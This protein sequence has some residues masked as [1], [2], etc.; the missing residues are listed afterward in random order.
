[1]AK[2]KRIMH[3]Y[4]PRPYQKMKGFDTPIVD[5][6]VTAVVGFI[7]YGPLLEPVL[8]V[9]FRATLGKAVTLASVPVVLWLILRGFRLIC[10]TSVELREDA[11]I[12]SFGRAGDHMT[13]LVDIESCRLEIQE[14][15]GDSFA[16][17]TMN[18]R[19]QR[20]GVAKVPRVYQTALPLSSDYRRLLE[21][22]R[23]SDVNVLSTVG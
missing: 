21:A 7:I 14:F 2:P 15:K 3:W 20:E 13:P 18:L 9:A 23:D 12:E 1:M 22:L 19:P 17:L 11:I 10:R 4:L 16:M 6:T 8:K 5:W